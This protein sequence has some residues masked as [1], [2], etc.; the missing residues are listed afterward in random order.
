M[1]WEAHSQY[2]LGS[3]LRKPYIK[4]I[5]KARPRSGPKKNPTLAQGN[6]WRYA[7]SRAVV[8]VTRAVR[9]KLAR[10]C[11]DSLARRGIRDGDDDGSW[12]MLE[13]VG[14]EAVGPVAS[15]SDGPG[16]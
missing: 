11:A 15:P 7:L 5:H 6:R 12:V 1:P 9:V 4:K 8:S 14:V 16:A 10:F 2:S 3:P 13:A